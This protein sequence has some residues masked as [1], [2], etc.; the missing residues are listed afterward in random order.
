[1][2][3]NQVSNDPSS[4]VSVDGPNLLSVAN[5]FVKNYSIESNTCQTAARSLKDKYFLK[6][7]LRD[8]S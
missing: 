4:I 5:E 2:D 8:S 3:S 7:T 6:K 1:M